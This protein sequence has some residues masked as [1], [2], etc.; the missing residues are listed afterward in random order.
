MRLVAETADLARDRSEKRARD[1]AS[2]VELLD[3]KGEMR[4]SVIL[5][6]LDWPESRFYRAV[7]GATENGVRRVARGVWRLVDDD[8]PISEAAA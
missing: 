7:E 5:E 6:A 2:L 1:V 3:K 4:T 8:A